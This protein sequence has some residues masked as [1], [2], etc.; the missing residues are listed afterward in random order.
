MYIHPYKKLFHAFIHEN[1]Q[2]L[3]VYLFISL[4]S[5]LGFSGKYVCFSVSPQF[6]DMSVPCFLLMPRGAAP[7]QVPQQQPSG[8]EVEFG[9]AVGPLLGPIEASGFS[10]RIGILAVDDVKNH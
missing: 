5:V 6:Q 10:Q 3:L 2:Y 4:C 9:V 8:E 7:H 1:I